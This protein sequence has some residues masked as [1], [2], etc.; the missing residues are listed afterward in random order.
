MGVRADSDWL[1]EYAQEHPDR[2]PDEAAQNRSESTHS[3]TGTSARELEERR[4]APTLH[5]ARARI[6]AVPESLNK[7]LRMHWSERH[8]HK[9]TWTTLVG[10]HIGGGV[11]CPVRLRY[12][13]AGSRLLDIDNLY[14]SAK[15]VI[16]AL[17]H[18][19]ILPDDDPTCVAEVI[20]SQKRVPRTDTH[21]ILTLHRNR[22]APTPGT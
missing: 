12:H 16:D 8:D 19:G 21:T 6:G 4:H 18:A 11:H 10:A 3:S 7:L 13:R 14:G 15:V 5:G 2:V 1:E 17:V 20:A 9:R 22:S